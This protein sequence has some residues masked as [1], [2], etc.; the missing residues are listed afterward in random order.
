[1]K[2]RKLSLELDEEKQLQYTS[3]DIRDYTEFPRY[4]TDIEVYFTKSASSCSHGGVG[5]KSRKKLTKEK[6]H[7]GFNQ[8]L[9][10]VFARIIKF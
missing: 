4:E 8:I 10:K 2:L 3:S 1:M 6:N 7:T 5:S 9:S